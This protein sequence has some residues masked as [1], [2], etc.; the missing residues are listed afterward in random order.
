[1]RAFLSP[2]K[3]MRPYTRPDAV[4]RAPRFAA[5]A[6]RLAGQ[7]RE[8]APWQLESLMK[9]SPKL[10]LQAFSLY[11]E[12]GVE[13]PL[14]PALYAYVGLQYKCM[15]PEDFTGEE[16][17]FADACLRIG[18]GLY[19]LLAPC[20]GVAPYRLEMGCKLAVGESRDLYA[21]WGDRLAKALFEG[22]GPVLNLASGEYARAIV[23]HLGGGEE[24]ITC[25]FLVRRGRELKC[26]PTE[27]KMARGR[28][29][30]YLVKQRVTDPRAVRD[31][32]EDGY[33]FLPR[34]S[35]E[36]TYTFAKGL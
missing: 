13:R 3:Q 20:D 5:D 33:Q 31:F 12:F 9:I 11:Q 7:L 27:A 15:A 21:H 6:A 1:M 29:A 28:M 4:L 34:L 16:L 30:R 24:W 22:G 36:R 18:S 17:A 35:G 10:G 23:P 14:A 32:C 2:A 8:L 25:R 19:G 26:L